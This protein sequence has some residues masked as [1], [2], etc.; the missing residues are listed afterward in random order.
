MPVSSSSNSALSLPDAFLKRWLVETKP[1]EYNADNID[2]RY[3]K[4][5]SGLVYILVQE[6][7]AKEYQFEVQKEDLEQTSLG[8]TAQLFRQYGISNPEFS[9]IKDYSD[10]Q[11]KD[12]NYIQTIMDIALRKKM[13]DKIKELLSIKEEKISIE[14]FYKEINA[15]KH[16]H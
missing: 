12:P 9:M 5:A 4:E 8:Y 14:D 3:E 6:K 10:K 1:E 13:I 11:L 16:E 2:E 7:M 15:H